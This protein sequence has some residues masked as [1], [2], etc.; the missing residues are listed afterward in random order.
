MTKA[1]RPLLYADYR[2]RIRILSE[3]YGTGP[4]PA[5]AHLKQQLQWTALPM[6]LVE[7]S[8]FLTDST[9]VIPMEEASAVTDVLALLDAANRSTTVITPVAV[10]TLVLP[11]ELSARFDTHLDQRNREVEDLFI[12]D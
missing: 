5:L 2:A 1:V 4:G 11:S 10:E 3:T 8:D 12:E 7:E 6:P 9:D